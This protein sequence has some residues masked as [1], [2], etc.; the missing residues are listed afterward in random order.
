MYEQ[1]IEEGKGPIVTERTMMM[2][3]MKRRRRKRK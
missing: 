2:M 1:G 3:M